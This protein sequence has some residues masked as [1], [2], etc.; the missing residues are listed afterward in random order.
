MVKLK[1]QKQTLRVKQLLHIKCNPLLFMAWGVNKLERKNLL[2]KL[3][4][5]LDIFWYAG[6]MGAFILLCSEYIFLSLPQGRSGVML[7]E[8][9]LFILL[10]EVIA[11]AVMLELTLFKVIRWLRGIRSNA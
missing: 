5:G 1:L 10:S 3:W 2:S 4:L 11:L 9:N 6:I 7:Y 8:P